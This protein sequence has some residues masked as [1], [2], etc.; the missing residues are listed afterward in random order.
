MDIR[1]KA[2]CNASFK[3]I[4]PPLTQKLPQRCKSRMSSNY[5]PN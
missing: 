1:K 5:P 2:I 3:A 4:S